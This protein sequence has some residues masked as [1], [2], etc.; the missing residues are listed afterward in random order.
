MN[1]KPLLYFMVVT[2][3]LYLRFVFFLCT[4]NTHTVMKLYDSLS[5]TINFTYQIFFNVLL[6][7]E[8]S[9]HHNYIQHGT[10]VFRERRLSK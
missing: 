7:S 10:G 5:T 4:H 2:A 1:V 8:L 9:L 6:H 3:V